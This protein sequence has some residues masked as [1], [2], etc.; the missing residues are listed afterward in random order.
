MALATLLACGSGAVGE[1]ESEPLG[2]A[3][4]A[5]RFDTIQE[6]TDAADLVVVGK[7]TASVFGRNSGSN[8]N[9]VN[10]IVSTYVTVRVEEVLKGEFTAGQTLVF[11]HLGSAGSIW[12]NEMPEFGVGDRHLLFLETMVWEGSEAGYLVMGPTGRV[13]SRC[14]REARGDLAGVRAHQSYGWK[15]SHGGEG[16]NCF[17]RGRR[18][19]RRG[20]ARPYQQSRT[21]DRPGAHQGTFAPLYA[22][23]SRT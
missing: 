9:E 17:C 12:F 16:R 21:V 15:V 4:W 13:Q 23:L 11:E 20:A 1:G 7:I 8:A 3:L 2:D 10:P 5:H 22:L 14:S 19:K 6:A 18:R